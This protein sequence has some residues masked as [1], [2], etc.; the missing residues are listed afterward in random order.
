M[1]TNIINDTIEKLRINNNTDFEQFIKLIENYPSIHVIEFT[2]NIKLTT[3][4]CEL[5]GELLK[6]NTTLKKLYFQRN[7]HNYEDCKYLFEG[8]KINRSLDKFYM[9][10]PELDY[11]A[12]NLLSDLIE[13]NKSLTCIAVYI[14]NDNNNS[15][16]IRMIN[17]LKIN[18]TLKQISINLDCRD[19]D[20]CE[21]FV[22]FIKNNRSLTNISIYNAGQYNLNFKSALSIINAL[23][24]NPSITQFH[25]L[26]FYANHPTWENLLN[27]Y[28]DRNR[29]NIKLKEM[30]LL[31]WS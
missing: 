8:L 3:K 22:D 12:S 21:Y 14:R 11:N 26:L 27:K 6:T 9:F 23:K 19:P 5:L 25:G 17:A 30:M 18:N 1:E 10:S 7:I 2:S 13:T 15:V 4:Y 28:C 20:V 31:D 16:A 24:Y 29:H